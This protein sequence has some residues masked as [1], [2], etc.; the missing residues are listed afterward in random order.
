[1]GF[2]P[3]KDSTAFVAF[4]QVLLQAIPRGPIYLILDNYSVHKSKLTRDFLAGPGRRLRFVF[5][6]T[7]APWLNRIE[8]TWRLAKGRAATNAWRDT[9]DAAEDAYSATLQQMG[10]H[11]IHP[12]HAYQDSAV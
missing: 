8:D 10:A 1:M 11:I 6:P 3:R 4:L 7:Y 2:W 12:C 5:L 9:L